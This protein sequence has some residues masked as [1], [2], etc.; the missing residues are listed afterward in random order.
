MG[1]QKTTELA[2]ELTSK[3]SKYGL[4]LSASVDV[5]SVAGMDLDVIASR[6]GEFRKEGVPVV[7]DNEKLSAVVQ[8]MRG[9]K[10]P[11][12][13]EIEI[14]RPATY[15]PSASDIDARYRISNRQ[16]EHAHGAVSDF[17]DYFN[18][19]FRRMRTIMAQHAAQMGNA[20][21]SL[22]HLKAYASGREVYIVGMVSRK[23]TTKNGN[24]LVE[25]EDETGTAKVI[26]VDGT[27]QRAKELFAK[28]ASI[29]NDEVLAVRGKVTGPFVIANELIWP[30]VPIKIPKRVED[31]VAIAFVSDVHVGSKLFMEKNFSRMISW[32][33]GTIDDRTR[34]LAG[35]VKYLV[36]GGDVADGIG[37][38]PNQ[39]RDLAVLDMYTQYRMFFEFM[40]AVPD[41]IHV[42]VL[43]GNHDAVQ[44]AEPQPPFGP[45]LIGDFKKDNVHIVSNPSM[46]TLHGLDVLTYHGT[47]L[48]SIISAVPG[49]SYAKPELAMIEVLKRRHLSPIYA[50]NI[51]V[52]SKSDSLVID[53]V[54]DILHM[55][56]IHKNGTANYHGVTLVN[57]GTWQARTDFQV[58]QGHIPT[59]CILP[60]YD[61][62]AQ[63]VTTVDFN[64]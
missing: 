61:S 48:D 43:A 23:S 41:Y 62:K 10:S 13:I 25:L 28:S 57:S 33:N 37:V 51:I 1:E 6:L 31:D 27:S 14:E 4:L 35:R 12:P 38:Y 17:V 63:S 45:D 49:M 9:E 34:D 60:V 8:A 15:K 36:V 40:E 20:L 50:G 19:R 53:T 54:P 39:D 59:P 58:R 56:H 24:V 3:L 5:D 64:Q 26:F 42:F 30:D 29:I 2:M 47:S 32:L 46:L 44:R 55:G 11:K 7:I 52:P 18:D 16:V 21:Q 22:E